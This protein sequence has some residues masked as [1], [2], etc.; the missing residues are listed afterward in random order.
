[1]EQARKTTE[2]DQVP[3]SSDK[4]VEL[5]QMLELER[6]RSY[7]LENE[8]AGQRSEAEARCA[9]LAWELEQLKDTLKKENRTIHSLE[10]ELSEA[11]TLAGDLQGDLERSQR[12]LLDN[13]DLYNKQEALAEE[14]GRELS[15]VE[16]KLR[17]SN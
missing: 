15:A 2:K 10:Q 7:S 3:S 16:E 17:Y 9:T 6:N 8:L 13:M 1:M 14:R 11:V 5:A 4:E 12:E